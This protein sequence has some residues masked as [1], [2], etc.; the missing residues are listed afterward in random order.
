M[1]WN[2]LCNSSYYNGNG[3]AA[4]RLGRSFKHLFLLLIL[5]EKVG[6]FLSCE[7]TFDVSIHLSFSVPAAV[8]IG[9][10]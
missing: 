1:L 6:P 3:N 7:L 9:S 8:P 2:K 4:T 5:M 10:K